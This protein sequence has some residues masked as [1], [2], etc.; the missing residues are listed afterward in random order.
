MKWENRMTN[1]EEGAK[2]NIAE[3]RFF[4]G[5]AVITMAIMVVGFGRSYYAAAP[6]LSQMIHVHA[7]VSGVWVSMFAAQVWLAASGNVGFHRQMGVLAALLALV[8]LGVGFETAIEGA[9]NGYMGPRF[10]R[11]VDGQNFLFMPL[12]NL[13]WF[14]TLV[15]LGV[16][17]RSKPDLHK[18][19]MVLA[20]LG[21][22]CR[23]R[24]LVCR[25][26][27]N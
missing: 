22:C 26:R 25:S 6:Q 18:R 12:G 17:S 10:S 13:L 16:L 4:I 11:D 19:F 23:L 3:H 27:R 24:W 15:V 7:I 1:D 5:F 8:V 2:P 9:R 21:G 14:G 20:M